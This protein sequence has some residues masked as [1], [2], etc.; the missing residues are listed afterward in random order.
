MRVALVEDVL[1]GHEPLL[2]GS[3]GAALEHDGFG[4]AADLLEQR[5][6]LHVAGAELEDV[7]VVSAQLHVLRVHDLG[8]DGHLQGLAGLREKL[9]PLFS[10]SLEGIGASPGLEGAATEDRRPGILDGLGGLEELLA[11]F[12]RAWAGHDDELV[13][14]SDFDAVADVDDRIVGLDLARDELERTPDGDD[15]GDAVE[16]RE[17]LRGNGA[18]VADGPD[19]GAFDA[20]GEV[21]LEPEGRELV[22]DV[23]NLL[24]RRV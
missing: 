4:E 5:E 24:S 15:F 2:E 1:G 13:G 14:S 20:L 16:G 23:A 19:D 12:D 3:S 10:E 11:G 8:N 21:G 22:D 9:E 6:V 17:G 7:G 18:L